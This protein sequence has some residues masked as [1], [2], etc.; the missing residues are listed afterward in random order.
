MQY[1]GS[2]SEIIKS[3]QC[4]FLSAMLRRNVG[5]EQISI[6]PGREN[7]LSVRALSVTT[8]HI[9]YEGLA[10]ICAIDTSIM[11]SMDFG[12]FSQRG[13]LDRVIPPPPPGPH[14][15]HGCTMFD[16]SVVVASRGAR[17]MGYHLSRDV[18][19]LGPHKTG[20]WHGFPRQAR[21]QCLR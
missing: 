4:L 2:L 8:S 13:W 15:L 21:R 12:Y 3:G 5:T 10:D 1:H 17:P 18:P 16:F 9:A 6:L 14:A 19:R 20:T 11:L 7:K